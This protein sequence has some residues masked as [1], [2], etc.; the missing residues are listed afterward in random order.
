M[1]SSGSHRFRRGL[2]AF[3]LLS[4][5]LLASAVGADA[6]AAPAS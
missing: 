4:T 1:V 2:A 3:G 6:Q 5:L